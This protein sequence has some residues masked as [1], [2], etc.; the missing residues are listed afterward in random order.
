MTFASTIGTTVHK[1][2]TPGESILFGFA[3]DELLDAGELYTGTPTVT[4]T[5]VDTQQKAASQGSVTDLTINGTPLV[6]T[7]TFKDDEGNT[8]EIGGGVQCRIS[9]GLRY[10]WYELLVSC[11]TTAGNTRE[12]RFWLEVN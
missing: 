12:D 4:C 7:V 5:S 8:V 1:E 3:M 6:N 2:K 9:D 11:G 10:V